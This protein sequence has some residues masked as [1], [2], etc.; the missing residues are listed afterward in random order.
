MWIVNAFEDWNANYALAEGQS[1]PHTWAPYYMTVYLNGSGQMVG[2]QVR[3]DGLPGAA[4]GILWRDFPQN[5]GSPVSLQLNA[6]N[7]IKFRVKLNTPGLS[8]GIFQIWINDVLKANYPTMN[9]R[10]SYTARGWNH[11][12]M[13][14][15]ANTGLPANTYLYRDNIS[16]W[17]GTPDGTRVPSTIRDINVR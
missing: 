7:K 9:F 4:T 2:Q 10:G 15:H 5:V 16:L 13:S 12:M 11:L 1:K 8:D 6:W 17:S 14:M 3:A